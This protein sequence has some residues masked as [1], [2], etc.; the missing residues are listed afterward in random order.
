M[1]PGAHTTYAAWLLR[2]GTDT[3]ASG[4]SL[5]LTLL[6]N[7]RDHHGTTSVGGF[8]TSAWKANVSCSPMRDF[9]R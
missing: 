2:P 3:P 6:A 8:P 4:L 9:S 1:E 5:R 7:D